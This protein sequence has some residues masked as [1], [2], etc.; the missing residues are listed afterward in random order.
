MCVY[1]YWWPLYSVWIAHTLP[2]ALIYVYYVFFAWAV[3]WPFTIWRET[4]N[5]VMVFVDHSPIF[6][7]KFL[8]IMYHRLILSLFWVKASMF[9][10]ALKQRVL[11]NVSANVH[12]RLKSLVVFNPKCDGREKMWMMNKLAMGLSEKNQFHIVP[13][14]RFLWCLYFVIHYVWKTIYVHKNAFVAFLLY[15]YFLKNNT[16]PYFWHCFCWSLRLF[17]TINTTS[18]TADVQKSINEIPGWSC[19]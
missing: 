6:I 15:I 3:H 18:S 13:W 16:S 2:C 4:A 8:F 7:L 14:R 17:I 12:S 19:Q 10:H 1:I 9:V 11:L 5:L